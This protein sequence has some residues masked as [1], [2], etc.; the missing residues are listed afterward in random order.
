MKINGEQ[1]RE[2]PFANVVNHHGQPP[3]TKSRRK[4]TLPMLKVLPHLLLIEHQ[5]TDTLHFFQEEKFNTTLKGIIDI[6]G[7]MSEPF[8]LL[9]TFGPRITGG[10]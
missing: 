2:D 8:A 1:E 10:S 6:Q 7:R 9:V 3:S 5:K 4:N